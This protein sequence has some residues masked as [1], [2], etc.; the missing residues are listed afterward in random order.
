MGFSD[1]GPA[2]KFQVNIRFV[3]NPNS[4]QMDPLITSHDLFVGIEIFRPDR[5]ILVPGR[6]PVVRVALSDHR[7]VVQSLILSSTD[8]FQEFSHRLHLFARRVCD[9]KVKLVAVM[10]PKDLRHGVPRLQ[11]LRPSITI[12]NL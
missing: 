2:D 3:A 5:D 1:S 10:V 4:I 8:R 9:G 12:I 7:R 6:R 11:L